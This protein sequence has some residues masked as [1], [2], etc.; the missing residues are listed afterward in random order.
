MF[1]GIARL[2]LFGAS[3]RDNAGDRMI[4]N[5]TLLFV[6]L[7]F[8]T[9]VG[10]VGSRAAGIR[11]LQLMD[12][13]VPMSDSR[14]GQEDPEIGW[15]NRPGVHTATEP[16]NAPM[17]FWSLGRRATRPSE[18]H[19]CPKG[20]VFVIGDSWTQ[21]YGVPD[22]ETYAWKL[23][24]LQPDYCIENFGNGGHGVLQTLLLLRRAMSEAPQKPRIVV[25]AFT[26]YMAARNTLR[27]DRLKSLRTAGNSVYFPPFVQKTD[28]GEWVQTLPFASKP[29]F[30]EMNSAFLNLL[31]NSYYWLIAAK[32]ER[33][34]NK[35]DATMSL[36]KKIHEEVEAAHAKF[37]FVWLQKDSL[38]KDAYGEFLSREKIEAIDCE[39]PEG[40]TPRLRVGGVGHPNGEYHS[41]FAECVNNWFSA[42]H[43]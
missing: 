13:T 14:W 8:L 10:E 16:G 9:F 5:L 12:A 18:A 21:A 38:T 30:G 7:T 27:Y 31:H 23:S 22:E 6:T 29:W 2:R 42:N 25:F 20:T 3:S 17:T 4:K 32:H 26:S 1:R 34:E 28:S 33:S 41:H 24:G 36:I 15:I 11:P 37:V 43:L 40:F 35:D 39:L 19:D